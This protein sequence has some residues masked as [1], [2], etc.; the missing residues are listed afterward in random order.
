MTD[1]KTTFGYYPGCSLH[2]TG[3]EYDISFKA[4][5]EKL[6]IELQEPKGWICCGATA[7]HMTSK[8]L[9]AALPVR[10]MSLYEQ[11][12]ISDIVVPCAACYAR[13]KAALHET[14]HDKE[15]KKDVDE[16]VGRPF[17]GKVKILNPLEVFINLLTPEKVKTLVTKPLT[18]M[19]V[20]CYYGCLLTR[21]PKVMQFDVCEYPMSMDKILRAVGIKTLDWSYKT[22]CCGGSLALTRTDIV[23]KLARDILEEARAVGANAIA[24]A[25][26]LCHA[27]LDTRQTEVEEKYAT[28]YNIPILY[29]TQ[30]LGLAFGVP[31][32]DLAFKK[33]LVSPEPLLA[34]TPA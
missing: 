18:Q 19:K 31:A 4:V 26:P 32:E 11:A 8:L 25:C 34:G 21:P 28:T 1:A 27:N 17:A 33:H 29:F 12:G 7:G 2:S 13:C 5:C 6:G 3:A 14:A 24:V 20:V 23:V 10:T 15:L 30:L 9:A 16:V 22:D